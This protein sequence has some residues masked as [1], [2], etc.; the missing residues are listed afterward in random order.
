MGLLFRHQFEGKPLDQCWAEVFPDS[1]LDQETARQRA[2]EELE[3][4]RRNYPLTITELLAI[5][6]LGTSELIDDLGKQLGATNKIPSK[7]IRKNGRR[8]VLATLEVSN[9][10]ARDLAFRQ[11]IEMRLHNQPKDAPADADD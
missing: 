11:L 2:T 7:V 3:W 5:Y 6:K 10:R 8:T 1:E 4:R 9:N